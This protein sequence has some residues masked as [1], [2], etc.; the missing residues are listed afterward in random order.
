MTNTTKAALPLPLVAPIPLTC[1][2]P[3][4]PSTNLPRSTNY[5]PSAALSI[6]AP[7]ACAGDH[8]PVPTHPPSILTHIQAQPGGKWRK[9]YDLHGTV[10]AVPRA[11]GEGV[12]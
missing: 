6:P 4:P 3:K 8:I 10:W 9:K 12:A 7:P 1:T 5:S 2:P 11:E